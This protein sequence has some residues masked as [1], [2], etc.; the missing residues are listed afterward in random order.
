MLSAHNTHLQRNESAWGPA[1][2]SANWF[3]AGAIVDSVGIGHYVFVAGSLGRSEV[4]DLG[5]PEPDTFEG[6]LQRRVTGWGLI[7]SAE[8]PP[9]RKRADTTPQQGYFPLEQATV[10]AAD[11]ILHVTG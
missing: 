8:V 5:A 3:G 2:M 7:P 11:A 4:L 9:A 10:D 6:H 1:G